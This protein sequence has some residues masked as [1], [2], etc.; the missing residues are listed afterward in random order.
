ME[1]TRCNGHISASFSFS[2]SL[3]SLHVPFSTITNLHYICSTYS[4]LYCTLPLSVDHEPLKLKYHQR[5]HAPRLAKK[6][7]LRLCRAL[8]GIFIVTS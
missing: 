8:D 3:F 5:Y 6:S 7:F 4:V 2:E 1:L